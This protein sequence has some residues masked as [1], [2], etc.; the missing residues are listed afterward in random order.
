MHSLCALWST[1]NA[2]QEFWM[3]ISRKFSKEQIAVFELKSTS[4]NKL[5]IPQN[6][7][8]LTDV[9]FQSLLLLVLHIFP[10]VLKSMPWNSYMRRIGVVK[11]WFLDE[12]LELITIPPKNSLEELQWSLS[13]LPHCHCCHSESDDGWCGWTSVLVLLSGLVISVCCLSAGETSRITA[14][15]LLLC[16]V[17]PKDGFKHHQCA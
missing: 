5:L 15:I 7:G 13:Y 14:R 12:T 10:P 16:F 2:F 3:W 11:K 8:I 9:I 17:V 6:Y 4:D 1:L